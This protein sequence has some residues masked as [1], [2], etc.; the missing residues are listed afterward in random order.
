MA[1][2]HSQMMNVTETREHPVW[3]EVR[4][5]KFGLMCLSFSRV[6]RCGGG[7]VVWVNPPLGPNSASDNIS[8]SLSLSCFLSS[9]FFLAVLKRPLLLSLP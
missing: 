7:S 3:G 8:D 4:Y 5:F 1:H 9:I 6:F 2:T